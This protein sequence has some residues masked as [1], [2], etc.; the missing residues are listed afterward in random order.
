MKEN[1]TDQDRLVKYGDYKEFNYGARCPSLAPF[2]TWGFLS[3]D[4]YVLKRGLR[5]IR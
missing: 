2:K 4:E 3:L 1:G 5:K